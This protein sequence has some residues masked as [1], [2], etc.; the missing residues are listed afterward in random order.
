MGFLSS[1]TRDERQAS[2]S[3]Y[4]E[5]RDVKMSLKRVKRAV[6]RR[7]LVVGEDRNRERGTTTIISWQRERF[8]W[9]VTR[10]VN[11][12]NSRTRNRR[13]E[14]EKKARHVIFFSKYSFSSRQRLI[15]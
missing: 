7:A 1:F 6:R 10:E 9:Q 13:G 3:S 4:Q 2:L 15:Q 11:R 14:K 12:G 5:D 8:S